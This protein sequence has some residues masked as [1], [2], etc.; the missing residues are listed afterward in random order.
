MSNLM[1][2]HLSAAISQHWFLRGCITIHWPDAASSEVLV[3]GAFEKIL[4]S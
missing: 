4:G 3:W 1:H 2:L